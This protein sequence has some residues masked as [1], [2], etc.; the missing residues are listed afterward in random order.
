VQ[1]VVRDRKKSCFVESRHYP[2]NDQVGLVC[3]YGKFVNP[4][5][6]T[7]GGHQRSDYGTFHFG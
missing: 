7:V 3:E 5:P 1:V 2:L 4:K 6:A